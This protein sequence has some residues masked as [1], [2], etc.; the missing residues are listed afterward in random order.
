ME[1][2]IAN[3][4]KRILSI[5]FVVFFIASMMVTVSAANCWNGKGALI[6]VFSTE[7]V[8]EIQILVSLMDKITVT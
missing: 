4:T 1:K 3:R 7:T 8:M 5:L 2:Q 6:R